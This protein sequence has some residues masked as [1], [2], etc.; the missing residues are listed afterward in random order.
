MKLLAYLATYIAIVV[1]SIQVYYTPGG[2]LYGVQGGDLNHWKYKCNTH[3]YN[4]AI[5]NILISTQ[6]NWKK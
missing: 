6:E 1:Y 2:A 3:G 5:K 4:V